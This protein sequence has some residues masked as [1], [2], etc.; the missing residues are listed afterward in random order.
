[1]FDLDAFTNF[2]SYALSNETI[3]TLLIA[4]AQNGDL[5]KDKLVGKRQRRKCHL[6]MVYILGSSSHAEL[7]SILESDR[8]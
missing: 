7:N 1:M 8:Q 4:V 2:L 5:I 3:R 6:G